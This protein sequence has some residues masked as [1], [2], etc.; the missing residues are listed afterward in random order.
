MKT[1]GSKY[2]P[3]IDGLRAI[4][5][6]SVVLYH[7]GIGPLRGG[8]VGVDIFFVISGYLITGIIYHEIDVGNFTIRGFYERR[9]RRIFPALFV[10]LF[11]V[12]AIAPWLLLPSDLVNLGH[13]ALAT[14]AFCSN[15]LFWRQSGY[16]DTASLFNPLLHTW[17]LAVEEQFYIV[18]PFLL[19]LVMKFARKRLAAILAGI[20]LLSFALCVWQQPV[21]PGATFYLAPFRAWEFLLGSLLAIGAVPIVRNRTVKELLA[22]IAL[23]A[24]LIAIWRVEEGVAFPGWQAAVPVV[25][26]TLLLHLGTEG[27]T[28]VHRLLSSRLMVS[29]G[30]I[31][32]SLY[33]WHW[34]LLVFVNYRRA[35][36]ELPIAGAIGLLGI[37][38]GLAWLSYRW[39][40]RP[41]RRTGPSSPARSRGALVA[42]VITAMSSLALF[43][44][45]LGI[46]RGWQSRMSPEVVALD[47]ARSPHI[48]FFKCD[49]TPPGSTAP[50]CQAGKLNASTR[51]LL[52]GDSHALAISPAFDELGR[53]ADVAVDLAVASACAPLID[54]NNP[55]NARCKDFNR[56]TLDYVKR[57]R[58]AQIYLVAS[59]PAYS[60]VDG[61]YSLSDDQGRTGNAAVF[62]AAMQRTIATIR[63]Y[64]QHI[65]LIGRVPGAIGNRHFGGDVPFKLALAKWA[66]TAPLAERS[67]A[68]VADQSNAY[69]AAVHQYGVD[70]Q[71]TLI[72]PSAWFCAVRTCRYRDDAGN[73]LYRDTNHLSTAGASYVAQHFPAALFAAGRSR[74]RAEQTKPSP[75]GD[76]ASS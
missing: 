34:P 26:T 46:D 37:A 48:P 43:A 73:L 27:Q 22:A 69:R 28:R 70:P 51:I 45:G 38:I 4:A 44:V 30:L 64:T 52:W 62:P 31:S 40:E 71:I 10:M 56:S 12:L 67:L 15:L 17:S 50:T 13:A 8:F 9:A 32:Y 58:P 16:F 41:F 65:V 36:D 76:G 19:T 7:F 49:G 25:A 42:Y 72:D 61:E 18:F 74:V 53:R 24:L 75:V 55:A 54:V 23:T 21:R 59:W 1:V 20:A 57:V 11:A 6:L 60:N 2:R 29:V 47:N 68:A 33:L 39:V 35:M 5:V 63:P 14:L 3:D 66:G